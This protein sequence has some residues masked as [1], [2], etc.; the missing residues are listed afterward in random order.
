[1]RTCRELGIATVAVYSELD[2]DAAHVR[3]ADEAYA[4]GGQT[5]AE[6]YLNTDA[7]LDAIAQSRRRRRAPRLRVLLR[8][9]RLRPR[10]HRRAASRGS[11]RRPRR[12]RSWATR[13]RRA[14][15]RPRADVASRARHPRRRSPTP[16][17]IVAF[18]DEYGCPVAIKAAYGGGGR[19]MKV[20]HERRRAR[21]SAFESAQREA[22][23]YF[24]RAE[25][26]LERYLTRP[27]PR[28]APGLRRHARQRR[29]PRRPRLLDAA[30]PPEADR[31]GARRRR[32]PTRPARAMGEA[33]VKVALGVRLRERRHRRDALP[34]RRVLLPRDEHAPPGRALRHRGGHRP[35]PRR[36]AAPRR[37]R[38]AAVVHRRTSIE[39]RGH[40][41][42]C[43]INAEDPAK[44]FLPS[45]GTITRLR[46]PVRSR[47]ALG[48]RLRRGRHDLA[49]L[50]QPHRQ[51][52]RV[53]T[54]PRPRDRPHAA[55][56]RRVRDRRASAR[57]S[58]RTSRCS[59][60]ADFRA[61]DALDQ[62]GRGRG[63]RRRVRGAAAA[64]AAAT[65][66]T[67]PTPPSRSS[68]ARCRSRSTARRFSVKVWLP[69]APAAPRAG[70][71]AG[72]GRAR[73]PSAHGGAA[74]GD[75]TV[76]RADAGHDRE[77]A[78]RA[79]G[80]TV[81]AGQ[82]I[83]RARGD[84]DGEPHQRRDG[85]H[86]HRDPRR[87][88]A[89]PS[90]PATSSPSSSSNPRRRA[91]PRCEHAVMAPV[92]VVDAFTSEP[93]RGNPAGVCFLDERAAPT[94]GCTRSRPR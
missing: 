19:G 74:A 12:S 51:A 82:A 35:R 89:T 38:R 37:R 44:N 65:A 79:S 45:P 22:Q 11:A 34:G 70:A 5:A 77:G 91:R 13:S 88:P 71:A 26:Y 36:R 8:E 47:R 28:R 10:D 21:E 48:R 23:A 29:V 18:G 52:R 56:A 33:A 66:P 54:R 68:S 30:P 73:A 75:G 24:G 69:D 62:V 43:R 40:S 63:R 3:Y 59:H 85:G 72:R 64:P 94:R 83:A 31:G 90:A 58:P 1:M 25:C 27:A 92:L 67:A 6:S 2:R 14:S 60:T 32:S 39:R 49:V 4:L 61:V 46:A 50:R 87:A 76:D 81:E 55:R 80:D 15:P 53:G 41:I 20:V 16:R 42:E 78:R 86:R 84:E 93:F 57:R 7:I 9:R 17:E